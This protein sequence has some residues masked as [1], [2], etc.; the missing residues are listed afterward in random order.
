M[1]LIKVILLNPVTAMAVFIALA[2]GILYWGRRI[3]AKE[4]K[5]PSKY[6]PYTGGESLK[7]PQGSMRYDAFFRLALMFVVLHVA[8]L[9]ISTMPFSSGFHWVALFFL[10]GIFVSVMVLV[11][12]R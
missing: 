6:L 2:L 7:A 8:G 10:F 4:K 9:V 5:E 1:E 3:G 11:D 12:V